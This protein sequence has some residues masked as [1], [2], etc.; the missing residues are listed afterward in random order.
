MCTKA[1]MGTQYKKP[2][3]HKHTHKHQQK[4][5]SHQIRFVSDRRASK[6]NFFLKKNA[7]QNLD[8]RGFSTL[9]EHVQENVHFVVTFVF[10]R[11]NDEPT[12]IFHEKIRSLNLF[13]FRKRIPFLKL[14]SVHVRNDDSIP[15]LLF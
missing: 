13:L 7:H 15:T 12:K 6:N 14:V 1:V 5:N 4:Q 2:T 8:L 10:L 3:H 11:R 9:F